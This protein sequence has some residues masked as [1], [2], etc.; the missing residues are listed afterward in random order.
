MIP[1][2][3][4]F[5]FEELC[6]GRALGDLTPDEEREL[7]GLCNRFGLSPDAAFDLLAA[8]IDSEVMQNS[9]E[10]IPDHLA[11]RLHDWADQTAALPAAEVIRPPRSAWRKV[12]G[13]P[14][15]GWLAAAAMLVFS[16]FLTREKPPV[17]PA[18]AEIRL[19]AEAADLIERKFAG[20]GDLT[21]AAGSVIWSDELQEG[22]MTLSG[23]P[24]N[25]P[26]QAQYQLWIVD[27][28]RDAD[29]PVDGGV[30]DIPTDGSPVVIPV[31]AKLALRNPQAFVITLEQPGGVVKSKQEK[32]VAL[33]KG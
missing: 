10:T 8:A 15:T 29:A 32:L 27:P 7:A 3:I 5:R 33:A 17:S 16:L 24:V 4:R 21:Q 30:F 12:V 23:I 26:G 6:A 14:L 1:P 20:L 31:A 25:D 18:R 22:Y 11:K 28:S 2:D 19:R 9:S 13:N